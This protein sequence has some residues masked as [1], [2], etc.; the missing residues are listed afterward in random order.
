VLGYDDGA[1]H[2]RCEAE[3][4]TAQH[5]QHRAQ[6]QVQFQLEFPV[7]TTSPVSS[8]QSQ[9]QKSPACPAISS[10]L[11]DSNEKL[12]QHRLSLPFSRSSTLPA[13]PCSPFLLLLRL[14][15]FGLASSSLALLSSVSYA[16]L[17]LVFLVQLLG[18]A[19]S[20]YDTFFTTHYS[21]SSRY[22]SCHLI[23]HHLFTVTRTRYTP[24]PI[25]AYL[26]TEW[27]ATATTTITTFSILTS[28]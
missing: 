24:R 4:S 9:S 11:A 20:L 14:S 6:R 22:Y 1:H 17:I 15:A 2:R 21:T 7:P 26:F 27:L 18:S 10:N 8:L 12:K 16:A 25:L 23:Y 5:S 28:S 19:L 13:P 3:T